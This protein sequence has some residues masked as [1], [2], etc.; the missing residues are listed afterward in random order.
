MK[1]TGEC[2][3]KGLRKQLGVDRNVANNKCKGCTQNVEEIECNDARNAH[4]NARK[5]TQCKKPKNARNA[6]MQE[7]VIKLE[8]KISMQNAQETETYKKRAECRPL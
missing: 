6:T 8:R 7:M 1:E 2:F 4:N 3:D 5:C